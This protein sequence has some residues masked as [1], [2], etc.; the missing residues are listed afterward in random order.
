MYLGAVV[1]DEPEILSWI[2]QATAALTKLR[3]IYIDN[4]ISLESISIFL[5]ACELWTMT[6][7]VEKRTQTFMLPKDIDRFT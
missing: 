4:N 6:A 2:A 1:S 3:L 7:E 5:Y